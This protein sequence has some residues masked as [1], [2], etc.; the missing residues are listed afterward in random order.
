MSKTHRF[1]WG[2]WF[3]AAIFYA[4]EFALRLSITV[5]IP[6]LTGAF[7]LSPSDIGVL[8]AM[9]FYAYAFMQIPAGIL[10]DRYGSRLM[11]GIASL[12]VGL[13]CLSFGS[14]L[15]FWQASFGR[16]L[17]GAGSAFAFVGCLK[18]THEWFAAKRF[19]F[20]VGLTNMIGVLGA[21]QGQAP[22]AILVNHIGWR[23][24]MHHGALLGGVIALLIFLLV[25]DK[26]SQSAVAQGREDEHKRSLWQS[27][28]S[29]LSCRSTWVLGIYAG[30]MVVA[31]ISFAELW[32]V[33]FLE[34]KLHIQDE[35]AALMNSLVFVGIAFGG[36]FWGYLSGQFG[37]RKPF[38]M[39][40]SVGA[41][42]ASLCVLYIPT[43]S[44]G[45]TS[46]FL[47]ALG[48]FSSS[49]LLCFTLAQEISARGMSGFV[50]GFTNMMIMLLGIAFQHVGS[51][52]LDSR[53]SG[54]LSL[55]D[56][57]LALSF[58]PACQ[59]FCLLI[60]LAMTETHCRRAPSSERVGE[61]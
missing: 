26:P 19:S 30:L 7:D 35:Q 34:V 38:M 31:I 23:D 45:L 21:I 29:V 44:V 33:V 15:G 16:C 58:M 56:F 9:Y 55:L 13:G 48:F 28:T 20:V 27:I 40:G 43:T 3:I 17:I 41:M 59:A 12:M 61:R 36:P 49:M 1:A 50:I 22:L 14:A 46:S 53:I 4:Y 18:V 37:L 6:E 52:L 2:V 57:Q 5:M 32:S 11:L 60:I 8:S 24:A 10:L 42:V 54:G 25:R 47:F 51:G 39:I